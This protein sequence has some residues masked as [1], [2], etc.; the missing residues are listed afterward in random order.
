MAPPRKP[1]TKPRI[2]KDPNAPAVPRKP[3]GAVAVPDA[4]PDARVP[5]STTRVGP[6]GGIIIQDMSDEKVGPPGD[7]VLPFAL[8][9]AVVTPAAPP[10]AEGVP[11]PFFGAGALTPVPAAVAPAV[12]PA[13]ELP[14][15]V[16][17]A[18]A[19]KIESW[20]ATPAEGSPHAIDNLP[21]QDSS[22]VVEQKAGE[23][24]PAPVVFHPFDR[25]RSNVKVGFD[26]KLGALTAFVGPNES[27]KTEY[28]D[29]L[30]LAVLQQHGVGPHGVDLLR[31]VPESAGQLYAEA[32]GPSGT[33]GFE[34]EGSRSKAKKPVVKRDGAYATLDAGSLANIF[35]TVAVGDLLSAQAGRA[36]ALIFAR[37]GNAKAVPTPANLSD[38]QDKAWEDA[39]LAAVSDLGEDAA[40]PDLLGAMSTI[41]FRE[42]KKSA[43]TKKSEGEDA[44]RRRAEIGDQKPPT[45][46]TLAALTAAYAAAL[47]TNAAAPLFTK[48]TAL[49]GKIA[50]YK[51]VTVTPLPEDPGEAPAVDD[52]AM[53]LAKA[54]MQ[55]AIGEHEKQ[56]AGRVADGYLLDAL[57]QITDISAARNACIC[58]RAY[59]LE[60]KR[61]QAEAIAGV[62][63]RMNVLRPPVIAAAKA[64][65]DRYEAECN[66]LAYARATANGP[67]LA[68]ARQRREMVL[69]EHKLHAA[70][71]EKLKVEQAGLTEAF[72]ALGLDLY[73]SQPPTDGVAEAAHAALE[74]AK[75][76]KAA[77]DEVAAARSRKKLHHDAEDRWRTLRG[78][79]DRL[80]HDML[81][82]V[83]QDATIAIDR[84]L[85]AGLKSKLTLEDDGR[86]VCR[87]EVVGLDGQ[88]H[89][90]EVATG[91]QWGA[92]TL[93]VAC[94]WSEGAPF[95][96]LSLD[97][98][99]LAGFD[100]TTFTTLMQR[101]VQL[102][103]E[104]LFTQVFVASWRA[105]ALFPAGW[106]VVEKT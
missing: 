45:E 59:D 71:A 23:P 81:A 42:Q 34:V 15:A 98:H 30:R 5:V 17:A 80:L 88:P 84:Y 16:P 102:Q 70:M 61:K 14:A 103:A 20:F 66:R 6:R 67:A 4:T 12:P 76:L 51:A 60:A 68:A 43:A 58:G 29:A 92:L 93:A 72:A 44:D 1:S 19:E 55:N 46:E 52:A 54:G 31:L 11:F 101:L 83:Q 35:P 105:R 49:Q 25:L 39:L 9:A 96:V 78:E 106:T 24:A 21:T 94:A 40:A 28:L 77:F 57:R 27:G 64:E 99:D 85:P 33:C 7:N 10:A 22:A 89:G 3:R 38:G 13:F 97:D 48:R 50:A 63:H 82:D 69:T 87:F 47:T 36:R 2:P 18:T 37:W 79:A 100:D 32:S 26:V 56:L 95:R 65:V 73:S 74:S 53:A 8:P 75:T 41:L 90:A 86:E 104:G 91:K 62:Q